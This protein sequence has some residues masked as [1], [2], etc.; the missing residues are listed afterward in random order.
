[1]IIIFRFHSKFTGLPGSK[2]HRGSHTRI[3]G[4]HLQWLSITKEE[5]DWLSQTKPSGPAP[6]NYFSSSSKNREASKP[7]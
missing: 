4:I 2:W 5:G 7:W 1:M 6:G 3:S